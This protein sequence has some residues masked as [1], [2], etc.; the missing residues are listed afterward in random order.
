MFPSVDALSAL[1]QRDAVFH[2]Q[3]CEE[4]R[5]RLYAGWVAAV[6]RVRS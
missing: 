6:A 4:R 1:W 5:N 3:M 2:P